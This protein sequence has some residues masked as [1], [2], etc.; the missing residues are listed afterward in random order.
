MSRHV[1]FEPVV[2][3]DGCFCFVRP[4]R[5]L[6]G[7]KQSIGSPSQISQQRMHAGLLVRIFPKSPVILAAHIRPSNLV[8]KDISLLPSILW[9][10]LFLLILLFIYSFL[11][12]IL[13]LCLFFS[14]VLLV[15]LFPAVQIGAIRSV[16]ELVQPA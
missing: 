15:E 10:Y 4:V 5:V 16:A 8:I 3:D 9:R 7:I 13:L 11:I 1:V 6:K 12:F 14:L 2:I